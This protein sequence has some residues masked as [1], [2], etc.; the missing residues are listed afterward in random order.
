MKKVIFIGDY[1]DSHDE[2]STVE[3]IQ[4][5]KDIIE[6]KTNSTKKVIMLIGNHDYHYFP[7]IGNQELCKK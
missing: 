3:Q 1:F 2:Y 7:E 6:Y 4:N 5:F